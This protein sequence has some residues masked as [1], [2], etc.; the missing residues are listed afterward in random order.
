MYKMIIHLTDA[1]RASK[2]L[3]FWPK[4][5]QQISGTAEISNRCNS[6]GVLF[7]VCYSAHI[8]L[9]MIDFFSWP[10]NYKLQSILGKCLIFVTSLYLLFT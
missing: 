4:F 1:E 6:V 8:S 5:R 10:I 2:K 9:K 7:Q 3:H